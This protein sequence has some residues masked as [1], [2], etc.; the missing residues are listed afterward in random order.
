MN[1]VV[2]INKIRKPVDFHPPDRFVV[3][4]AFTNRLQVTGVVKKHGMAIHASLRGRNPGKS[5]GFHAR[6]AIAAVNS[7]VSDVV[8]VA[9]LHGLLASNVLPR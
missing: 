3:T 2:E 9:E 1:A 8:F 4:I 6:M 5:G 7:V